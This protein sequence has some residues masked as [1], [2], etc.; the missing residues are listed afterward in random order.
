ML[1]RG[2]LLLV[3]ALLVMCTLVGCG[4]TALEEAQDMVNQSSKP[5]Q[6]EETTVLN[7]YMLGQVEDAVLAKMEN[8]FNAIITPKYKVSVDFTFY[9]TPEVY[10][11]EMEKRFLEAEDGQGYLDIFLNIDYEVFNQN[12]AAGRLVDISALVSSNWT[13]YANSNEVQVKN[14]AN[15]VLYSYYPSVGGLFMNSSYYAEEYYPDDVGALSS[16]IETYYGLPCAY[17]IGTLLSEAGSGSPVFGTKY[18]YLFVKKSV[19]DQYY[20]DSAFPEVATKDEL[21]DVL[22]KLKAE[23][24][25][26]LYK[27]SVIERDGDYDLRNQ[28]VPE[29]VDAEGNPEEFYVTILKMPEIKYPEICQAMF[30]ISAYSK[31]VT[32]SYEVLHELYTNPLLHNVLRYGAE[33]ITYNINEDTKTVSLIPEGEGKYVVDSHHTG[34][35]FTIYPVIEAGLSP[36]AQ[37]QAAKEAYLKLYEGYLQ[38]TDATCPGVVAKKIFTTRVKFG[39]YIKGSVA[40]E[41]PK[42]VT[43]NGKTYTI[44]YA[45]DHSKPTVLGY[46]VIMTATCGEEEYKLQF[47]VREIDSGYEFSFKFNTNMSNANTIETV[48]GTYVAVMPTDKYDLSFKYTDASGEVNKLTDGTLAITTESYNAGESLTVANGGITETKASSI[49]KRD[50]EDNINLTIKQFV[51]C[52]NLFLY[53][54]GTELTSDA[55]GFA[56]PE[57]EE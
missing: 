26:D 32:S 29:F 38:N 15:E 57:T 31:S 50:L 25:E 2:L 8:D 30:C 20:F 24:G 19:A 35:S 39:D 23:L 14:E 3:C 56:V 40:T 43:F 27:S 47:N 10:K 18:Q 44:S 16:R 37:D 36:E 12:I 45:V 7:F 48:T 11:I 4:K 33:G 51:D 34:N 22:N 46:Q 5:I 54:S 17:T 1:K 42:E 21:K 9:A 6:K 52:L 28:P 41:T 55:F 49:E 13:E 53:D